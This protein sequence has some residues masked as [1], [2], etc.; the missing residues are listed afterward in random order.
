[1]PTDTKQAL[2]QVIKDGVAS[3]SLCPDYA[4]QV[5]CVESLA[6]AY[7]LVVYGKQ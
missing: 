6:R 1:M 3:L 5:R 7:A 4:D 2:L